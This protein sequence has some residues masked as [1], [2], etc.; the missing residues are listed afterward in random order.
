MEAKEFL[1]VYVSDLTKRITPNDVVWLLKEFA[2]QES[3]E[4][5][6]LFM[7]WY[8]SGKTNLR[9][10]PDAFDEWQRQQD[11]KNK[12]IIPV[13]YDRFMYEGREYFTWAVYPKHVEGRAVKIDGKQQ[14]VR[15]RIDECEWLL[16]NKKSKA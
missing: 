1:K 11:E 13:M 14:T 3:K 5:T 6:M 8:G 4:V 10:L 15:A 9:M 2:R 7:E 16:T 12:K